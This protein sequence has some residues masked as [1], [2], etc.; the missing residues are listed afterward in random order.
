[1]YI[2]LYKLGW[3]NLNT[4]FLVHRFFRGPKRT[5]WAEFFTLVFKG[6][7]LTTPTLHPLFRFV[8][9]FQKISSEATL[10]VRLLKNLMPEIN[11]PDQYT[12]YID[13]DI[14]SKPC[15]RGSQYNDPDYYSKSV[16]TET[17]S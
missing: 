13:M 14:F 17:N 3:I 7:I 9:P 16:A 11:S 8:R 6:S 15:L 10:I 4:K 2:Y 5:P 12:L 1:M